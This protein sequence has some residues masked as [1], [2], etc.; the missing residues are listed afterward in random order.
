MP[1]IIRDLN[2]RN[3]AGRICY[4]LARGAIAVPYVSE[5]ETWPLS[6]WTAKRDERLHQFLPRARKYAESLKPLIDLIAGSVK[7]STCFASLPEVVTDSLDWLRLFASPLWIDDTQW[8]QSPRIQVPY[9]T[10]ILCFQ[11]NNDPE[12]V[13]RAVGF[14][15]QKSKRFFKDIMDSQY[16]SGING[17]AL[18]IT[19]ENKTWEVSAGDF[20]DLGLTHPALWDSQQQLEDY[21]SEMA[22]AIFSVLFAVNVINNLKLE[23]VA[24][25][26]RVPKYERKYPKFEYRVLRLE[27]TQK[28]I[29]PKLDEQLRASPRQHLRRGHLRHLRSGGITWVSPCI[30]GGPEHGTIIKD[31]LL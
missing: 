19:V 11:L 24:P 12:N 5:G 6:E 20:N 14:G 9:S 23:K 18:Q 13:F 29:S 16:G 25:A 17:P 7:L 15:H 10:S 8:H 4:D 2:L 3:V 31:Y 21:V 26:N 22:G 28:A 1:E 27:K 30:V